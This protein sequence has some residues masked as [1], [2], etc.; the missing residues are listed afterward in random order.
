MSYSVWTQQLRSKHRSAVSRF[1][2]CASLIQQLQHIGN[3]LQNESKIWFRH[4]AENVLYLIVDSIQRHVSHSVQY[5]R[6]K[7][8]PFTVIRKSVIFDLPFLLMGNHFLQKI[9]TYLGTFEILQLIQDRSVAQRKL[10]NRAAQLVDR[11]RHLG[12]LIEKR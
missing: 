12:N 7:P 11:L 3:E 6:A 10:L 9:S 2:V 5:F 8:T 1:C 4:V